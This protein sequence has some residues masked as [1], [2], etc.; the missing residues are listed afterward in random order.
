MTVEQSLQIT[1][2]TAADYEMPDDPLNTHQ[3]LA[4]LTGIIVGVGAIFYPHPEVN[5]A[6]WATTTIITFA[7]LWPYIHL[8]PPSNR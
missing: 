8:Q 4:I 6:G 5:A 2:G 7:S 3:K 1:R